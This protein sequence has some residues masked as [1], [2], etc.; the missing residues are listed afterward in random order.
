MKRRVIRG[1]TDTRYVKQICDK[2][3]GLLTRRGV[4]EL[5]DIY[6]VGD[7][8]YLN[9]C[10]ELNINGHSAALYCIFSDGEPNV[11]IDSVKPSGDVISVQELR[12]YIEAASRLADIWTTVAISFRSCLQ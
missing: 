1:S 8:E 9:I 2:L 5:T 3:K 6:G 4:S 12:N 10:V 11:N 7:A